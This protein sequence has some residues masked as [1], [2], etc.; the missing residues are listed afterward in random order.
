MA[1][2]F[3]YTKKPADSALWLDE[4]GPLLN[5]LKSLPEPRKWDEWLAAE[6]PISANYRESLS[7]LIARPDG[8]VTR[9]N[10]PPTDPGMAFVRLDGHGHLIEFASPGV[11]TPGHLTTKGSGHTNPAR[12]DGEWPAPLTLVV[13]GRRRHGSGCPVESSELLRFFSECYFDLFDA[14]ISVDG[15]FQRI[16]A[17]LSGH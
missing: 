5:Y 11:K 7:P 16:A 10:P 3:G 14:A 15:Q 2:S 13:P 17:A 1:A 8:S 6:A 4:R 12:D 9:E